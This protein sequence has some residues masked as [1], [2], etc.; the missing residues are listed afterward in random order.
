MMKPY[1]VEEV[2]RD[3]E[4]VTDYK[5][6]VIDEEIAS[7]Q[8]IE[9]LRM[10]M[11]GVVENG[12]AYKLKSD[13][14]RFAGK[15][16]TSQQNYG[17]R[18]R[19]KEYQA[20]FAGYFPAENPKYSV[21]VVIYNPSR[22][23]YYGGEVAGP[24]FREIADN[25]YNSM[26]EVHDAL[27]EGPRPVLYAG[28]L[29]NRDAGYLNEITRVLDYVNVNLDSLPA[30]ELA[31]VDAGDERVDIKPWD[32]A[33]QKFPNV[34]GMRLRDAVY[35]LENEGYRVHPKGVGRVTD[36]KW[37]KDGR[38]QRGKDVTLILN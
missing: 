16:G 5:P 10:L 23:G 18:R 6:T 26:I 28:Q 11:E 8:T 27:N 24:V 21:I 17:K 25:I 2:R 33:A 30:T 12:T 19:K 22:G 1:L 37:H 32:P 15:T 7:Q 31:V 3:G 9:Q 34:R 38:G 35:V 29:P 14:Y 4:V 36:Q 13:Q 20:S